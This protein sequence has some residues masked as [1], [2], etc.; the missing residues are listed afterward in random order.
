MIPSFIVDT[1]WS[2][3]VDDVVALR[4]MDYYHVHGKARLIGVMINATLAASPGSV[5]SFLASD[6]I[7]GVPIGDSAVPNVAPGGAPYQAN[8][9][10]IGITRGYITGAETYPVATA[11]YRTLLAN[12]PGKVNILSIGCLTNMQAL[13][14]SAADAIS[15]LTGMQLI[16]A[17]VLNTDIM[18]GQY[19]TGTEYNFSVTA[20]AIAAAVDVCANWPNPITYSGFE[21]GNTV[22]TGASVSGQQPGDLLA[23]AMSD[24]GSFARPSW[25]PMNVLMG[26]QGGPVQ[27]GYTTVQGANVVNASTGANTFTPNATGKDRYVKKLLTDATYAATINGLIDKTT[28]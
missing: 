18:G 6:G 7:T 4:V 22:N 1:D 25:D 3:D 27:G 8:L 19:P 24:Y 17:K 2:S 9:R 13:M 28:W 15:P 5:Q 20:A 12:A 21:V 14:N 26:N 11:A 23:Q 16:A 10:S